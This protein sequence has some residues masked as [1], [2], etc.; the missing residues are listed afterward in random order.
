MRISST[1]GT[2]LF[3]TTAGLGL[4]GA[5]G[6]GADESSSRRTAT[7][8]QTPERAL[9]LSI[10][11]V[12]NRPEMVSDGDALM[13]V[14]I[15][16]G[17]DPSRVVIELNGTD[18]TATFKHDGAHAL[19]ALVKGL[20]LGENEI[21][22]WLRGGNGA[23]VRGSRASLRVVNHPATGPVFSGP[24]EHPY[25]C[26]THQFPVYPGGPM[27]TST[28]IAA[29]CLVS[30]RT[31]YVYR[32]TS[33]AFAPF[34]IN[35]PLPSDLTFTT[36]NEGR[37][38]PYVV[39]LETGVLNRA[40]YQIAVLDDPRQ[41][42]DG[43]PGWNGKLVYTFGGG[44][45]GGH[46]IQG[47]STGG[48]LQNDILSRGFAVASASLNVYGNNCNDVLSAET[49]MMVK[50][51]FI[52]T[53][54]PVR[55]TIGWGSSG[56]AVQ[57]YTIADNYPGI[58]DGIVPRQSFP[59]L[60]QTVVTD[61]RLFLNYFRNKQQ[62]LWDQE[63]LQLAS[64]FGT[65]GQ[66]SAHGEGAHGRFEP[67]QNRPGWPNAVWNAVVPMEVRYDP[68]TNPTGARPTFYD[69][70]VNT[71]G[72]GA[73]GFA[74]R[75]LDNVGV[76]YGLK[77][78]NLGQITK[79]QFLDMNENIGGYDIDFN[80]IAGRTAAD[81]QALRAAYETGKVLSGGGGLAVTPILDVDASYTDFR[82]AGD[83]HLKFHHFSTRERL[84]QANGSADNMVMWS[85]AFGA[86]ADAVAQALDA[87]DRWLANIE[88][89]QSSAPRKVKVLRNK[90]A[91]LTDGCFAN[92]T[93]IAERQFFGPSGSSQCNTL[94][95]SAGYPL[96]MAGG[97]LANNVLKCQLRPIDFSDYTVPFTEEERARLARIFPDGVCDW[98]RPGVEQRG[99]V[100]TWIRYT[101]VGTY[102]PSD[103][104]GTVR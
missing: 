13:R 95:P 78:L 69:H 54:G 103:S 100:G 55:Y 36:T 11:T 59:D 25:Y 79:G 21:V 31:D 24:Q 48:V 61:A 19:L 102:D 5:C 52:E 8:A 50:E 40:I 88:S 51:H 38:V 10:E 58:L 71:Y 20:R 43:Y 44:C 41:S 23:P 16:P 92:Q 96:D 3:A 65:F 33:G 90:P 49:A 85:G 67:V 56:G 60:V 82:A 1:I 12:S 29:P 74:R 104:R 22:G 64:G 27:L 94:Y 98:T 70:N 6:G 84:I 80:F 87:M 101:G 30:T 28:Q 73:D 35:G 46:Y 2:L 42:G 9:P 99:L 81:V 91:G 7:A 63:T 62:G 14:R 45:S 57:Q 17:I 39:R 77:A 68:I 66:F 15:N 89:D 47:R 75:P 34:D 86:S 32:N 4:L 93:F 18:I 83:V 37:S 26:Q 72:R 97:P 53:Y 76:Q